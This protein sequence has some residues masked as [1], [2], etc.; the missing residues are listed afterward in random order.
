MFLNRNKES[1][2]RRFVLDMYANN[3]YEIQR[4]R[5]LEMW[6]CMQCREIA[7]SHTSADSVGTDSKRTGQS[8]VDREMRQ[9]IRLYESVPS[10]TYEDKVLV[11]VQKSRLRHPVG[12]ESRPPSVNLGTHRVV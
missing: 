1:E 3:T 7:S 4:D 11:R 5:E 12:M 2:G 10:S 8:D 6:Q 9:I